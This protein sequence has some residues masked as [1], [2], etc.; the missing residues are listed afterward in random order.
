MAKKPRKEG[1]II[2]GRE[3]LAMVFG[4]GS[5]ASMNTFVTTFLALYLL[6]VGISP[7]IAAT[8]LLIIRA[9]DAIN[10][11]F[12]GYIVDKYRFKEGRNRFTKWLFSGR[13]MPWFRIFFFIIPIGTIVMFTLNTDWPTWAR[14]TQYVIGYV[15]F[16]IGMTVT[17]AYLLLPISTTDN[18]DERTFVLAWNGLGQGFGSLP[19][20]FLGTMFIAGGFG[21]VGS[22]IVFS[23]LGF[24]LAIIPTLVV[25]ERNVVAYDEAKMKEYNIKEMFQALRGLPELFIFLL[26]VLLWGLFYT[27]GYGLFVAYYIFENANIAILMTLFGVLPSI[28]LVPL[29]PVIFKRVDKIVVARIACIVFAFSG[30]IINIL[31][32]EFFI[33]NLV[34]IYL[35][36]LLQSTSFVMTMFAGS[37]LVPDIAETIRYRTGKDVAGS[38]TA[39]YGFTTKLVGTLVGSVT[40]FLL[41]IYGWV[42]VEA[43]SFEELAAL[44][45]QGI[46]LQTER[47]VEGLWNVSY[48]FPLIGFA[49]AAVAFFF[50]KVK[51]K[52]VAIYMKCNSGEITRE[53]ADAQLAEM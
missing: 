53:E 22:A 39:M 11:V 2:P 25:K 8:V 35:L 42:A 15:L 27:G 12:F 44:N 19:V 47:A 50:V 48:L 34:V 43:D 13:Y 52:K 29:L 14:I 21:Y 16:D 45:E 38:V 41:G 20:I 1:W 17:G 10:D 51:R 4:M 40:L 24:I 9:F 6:M 18:Y 3:K 37:M 49:L 46:G 28:I 36:S 33:N 26:G 30:V 32:P 31:G 5:F 7:I 23:I